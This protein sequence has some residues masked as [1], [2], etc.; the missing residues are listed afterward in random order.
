MKIAILAAI[1]KKRPDTQLN[2][3][4]SIFFSPDLDSLANLASKNTRLQIISF[5]KY[6]CALP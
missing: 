5:K 1:L 3:H 4:F 6:G 2:T